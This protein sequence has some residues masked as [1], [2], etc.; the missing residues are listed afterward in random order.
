M[1]SFEETNNS[2]YD[3]LFNN[4]DVLHINKSKIKSE[5]TPLTKDKTGLPSFEETNKPGYDQVFN[6][7]PKRKW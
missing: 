1:A 6:N 3:D 4:R 2:G 7:Q 5:L